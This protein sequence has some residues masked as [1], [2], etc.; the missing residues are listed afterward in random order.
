VKEQAD[1]DSISFSGLGLKG[2][3]CSVVTDLGYE[4]PTPIQARSIPILLSGKDLIALAQTGTG[5]TAAFALPLLSNIQAGASGAK[6]LVLTPTRELAIQVAEAFKSYSRLLPNFHVVP[7][8]G[9]QSMNVQIRQLDRKPQ[10]IVGTPGRVMDHLKRKTLSL[11]SLSAL[12]LDEADEMLSMGFL[13][14]IEWIIEQSPET[15]QTA[16]FSATMPKAIKLIAQKY[17][18]DPEEAV[19]ARN[20]VD[21]PLITEFHCVVSG[22]NA[23]VDAL[24]RVLEVSDFD[25]MLI[26][27]R[28]KVATLELAEKLEARGFSSKALNGD[29][30]QEA[31]ERTVEGF[32]RG[33]VDVLVATDVAAR[34]LHVD[35]ISH[36]LNFDIPFDAETYTH[37]IGRTG[38]A[39]RSGTAVLFV[40]PREMG[41][42]RTIERTTSRKIPRF[43]MPT[44]EDVA[45]IRIDRFVEKVQ[46]ALNQT[47]SLPFAEL[48]ETLIERIDAPSETIAAAL[49][50]IINEDTPL[51]VEKSDTFVEYKE[52]PRFERADRNSRRR[53]D[54]QGPRPERNKRDRPETSRREG[55]GGNS[56]PTRKAEKRKKGPQ[57]S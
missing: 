13:D 27:V 41:M 6:I 18:K 21:T 46:A 48:V 57:Q 35:R 36:V 37:R 49:C 52:Q 17:L 5:K 45:N 8:Y 34:G 15:R 53:P 12:V 50:S 14:D 10:V 33:R 42:L 11:K 32:K 20:V 54:R 23:K 30:T 24:T 16:L 28:T 4:V 3:L 19:M 39:G 44:P 51:F 9:G 38:R 55:N 1:I 2:E 43:E 7:I 31:R 29:M 40:S 26:F 47:Q 25:G 56:R 22:M